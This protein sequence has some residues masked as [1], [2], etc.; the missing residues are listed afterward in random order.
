MLGFENMHARDASRACRSLFTCIIV[1][2]VFQR[3]A[4]GRCGLGIRG[5]DSGSSGG[6]GG[7]G[8]GGKPTTHQIITVLH[9]AA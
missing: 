7:G 2:A 5:R 6:G 9:V 4:P 8:G 3:G 1:D